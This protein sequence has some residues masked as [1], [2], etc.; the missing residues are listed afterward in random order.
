MGNLRKNADIMLTVN[1]FR[2]RK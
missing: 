1:V 2:C